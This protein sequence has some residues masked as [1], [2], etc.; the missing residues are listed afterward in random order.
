MSTE[1]NRQPDDI[2]VDLITALVKEITRYHDDLDIRTTSIGRTCIIKIQP[3]RADMGKVTGS[4]GAHIKALNALA[5]M[6]GAK[7]GMNI[8]IQLVEP[9]VGRI[10]SHLP[11]EPNPV[12]NSA[13][14]LQLLASLCDAVFRH[15][16][17]IE[18]DEEGIT[19]TIAVIVNERESMPLVMAANDA[20]L[21]M[22]N[23]IGK[24]NGR[25]IIVDVSSRRGMNAI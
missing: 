5:M 3:H 19:T 7:H 15:P 16:V 11:F 25:N 24:A 21:V 22:F 14:V 17:E 12:W 20:I 1:N 13:E 6:I 23:A 4:K 10:D 18:T 8:R 2:A 9:E